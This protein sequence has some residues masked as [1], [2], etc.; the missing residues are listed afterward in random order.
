[1]Q[2]LTPGNDVIVH[3]EEGDA[4]LLHVGSGQ[5]YGLNRSGLIVWNAIASGADP[6]EALTQTWPN[7]PSELLQADADALISQLLHAGLIGEDAEGPD[8]AAS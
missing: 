8:T 6:V 1:M 7:R 5:Y 2:R 3:Q 4:F